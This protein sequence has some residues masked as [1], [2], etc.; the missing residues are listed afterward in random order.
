MGR[1]TLLCQSSSS[2]ACVLA[3]CGAFR[4][5]GSAG[6]WCSLTRRGSVRRWPVDVKGPVVPTP[7]QHRRCA[8]LS[9]HVASGQRWHVPHPEN[10][11]ET[12]NAPKILRP[13]TLDLYLSS[14]RNRHLWTRFPEVGVD[15]DFALEGHVTSPDS[16]RGPAIK[17]GPFGFLALLGALP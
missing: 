11:A 5:S 3:R 12:E 14:H 16:W 13:V 2:W 8:I 4:G 17:I 7:H 10:A 15:L 6:G 1:W 9:T